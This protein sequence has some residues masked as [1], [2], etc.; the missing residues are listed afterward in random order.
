MSVNSYLE[1]LSHELIIRDNEK[2]NIKKSI[3]VIKSRL[4]S[5]FGN[6]IVE[7]FC[8]G[9]YTRGT[10][11][12]RKV[13]ENSDVDYMVVFSNSFLYAPQTLLNKLRDFVRTYYSKSEI[14]QSNP[15]IVLELNHIKFELVPAYSNNMYLWQ[16]NHYRIPAKASDYNDWIDTCP[17]DI[18]SRLTR[19][20]VESNNKLKPA[21]RIIKYW[22]S[23]NNNVYSS[24]ELESAI[25]E[26][27]HCYWRTS[28]QDYFTAI[29]ESLIYN[30]GTPSWKVDK[31]SSLKKWYNHA[32]KEEYIWRN[33]TQSNLYMEN[34]L[35]SIK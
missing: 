32:L 20:N 34:I 17:D 8:F 27:M 3:E 12:P 30:F 26:N 15:T 33:Y 9:S 4:K 29:T 19:L 23:L 14:Y 13:N 31:I 16:E 2:E 18:N 5:Y 10:M 25:L 22:N 21:I 6:N 24:Y 1:N 28:I 35:P 7:T 11:L